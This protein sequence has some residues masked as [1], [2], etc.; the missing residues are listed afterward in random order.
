MSR[1]FQ[2]VDHNMATPAIIQPPLESELDGQ[3]TTYRTGDQILSL[4]WQ[5]IVGI[6]RVEIEI[7]RPM[8]SSTIPIHKV[9]YP[10]AQ[11]I[12]DPLSLNDSQYFRAK[13]N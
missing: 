7:Y 3:I 9:T 2:L 12:S 11:Q 10:A 8:L 4:R 5:N 1:I 13:F 6:E